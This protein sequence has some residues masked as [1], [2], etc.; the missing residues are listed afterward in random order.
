MEAC[1]IESWRFDDQRY[2]KCFPAGLEVDGQRASV[3]VYTVII[4]MEG[5][6]SLEEIWGLDSKA[7]RFLTKRQTG[8]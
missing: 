1:E 8:H 5:W 7:R 4:V 2:S 6:G 3:V